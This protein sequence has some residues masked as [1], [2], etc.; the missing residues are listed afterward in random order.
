VLHGR[1]CQGS[2]RTD[3][4]LHQ[5]VRTGIR[6]HQAVKTGIRLH[7]AV[8]TN[9]RLHQAVRTGIR[10]HQAV[11]TGFTLH[12]AVRTNIRLH[13]AVR[14][15][16]KLCIVRSH[17]A[18]RQNSTPW[19]GILTACNP[20]QAELISLSKTATQ[21]V[22]VLGDCVINRVHAM[23]M[24]HCRRA[25]GAIGAA[26]QQQQQQCS[27]GKQRGHQAVNNTSRRTGRHC[28][29]ALSLSCGVVH[30]I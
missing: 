24:I 25:Q 18:R 3:I 28:R 13:Q 16:I 12:Q 6:L 5:A 2:V 9:I 14:T 30:M 22:P 8:R 10:L 7:Q 17:Y 21:P 20:Q 27:A 15:N 1:G 26:P 11:R 19:R 23:V 29:R 4:R